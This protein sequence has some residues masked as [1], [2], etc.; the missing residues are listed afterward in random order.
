MGTISIQG[1]A[2]RL[3]REPL[4]WEARFGVSWWLCLALLRSLPPTNPLAPSSVFSSQHSL[5]L[6][7]GLW[8]LRVPLLVSPALP[9]G[10]SPSPLLSSVSSSEH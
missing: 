9:M 1:M 8:P 2:G 3:M 5:E 7:S 4:P 10:D 6:A